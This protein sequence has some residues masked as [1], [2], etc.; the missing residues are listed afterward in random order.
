MGMEEGIRAATGQL[1]DLL[2]KG[3][4][5]P[6]RQSSPPRCEQRG[7]GALDAHPASRRDGGMRRGECAGSP[8]LPSLLAR[9]QGF[10][11]SL[12]EAGEFGRPNSRYWRGINVSLA[13]TSRWIC[14]VPS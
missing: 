4:L 13:I 9:Q 12:R 5:D 1:D 7:A 6:R 8:P 2:A 14:E 11:A 3:S 10:C